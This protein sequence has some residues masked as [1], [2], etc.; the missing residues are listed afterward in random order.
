ML[1]ILI[2]FYEG[3]IAPQIIRNNIG[4]EKKCIDPPFILEAIAAHQARKNV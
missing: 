1:P 2:T 3:C 4:K